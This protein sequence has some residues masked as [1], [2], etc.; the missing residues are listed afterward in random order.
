M[1][2]NNFTELQK[3]TLS[4]LAEENAELNQQ[5]AALQ[6][7]LTLTKHT[8]LQFEY[9]R[10]LKCVMESIIFNERRI[11]NIHRMMNC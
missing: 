11:N 2:K 3:I 9:E 5:K 7:K 6:R 8:S 1:E 4:M 10:R